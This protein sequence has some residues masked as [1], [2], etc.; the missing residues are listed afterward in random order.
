MTDRAFAAAALADD[1]RRL[2]I[3]SVFDRDGQID[4]FVPHSLSALRAHASRIVVVVNGELTDGSRSALAG[5]ADEIFVRA[6]EGFDIGA[7]RAALRKLG[8]EIEE[9]D[10][11][12]LTNDTWY[13]PMRPWGPVF[14]RMDR[15][16]CDFWGM[17]DHAAS[18]AN[19][20]T[21]RGVAPYH[22]QSYWMAVRRPMF[23]SPEWKRYWEDLP[24]L[25][26]YV[27]A[28]TEHELRFTEHFTARGRV[29]RAAFPHVLFDTENPSLFEAETLLER[30]CPILKRRPLFHW[31]PL[32]DAYASVGAWT[33]ASAAEGGYP[34]ELILGN[35]ARTVPPKA[36]NVDVGLLSVLPPDD[37]VDGSD[38]HGAPQRVVAVVHADDGAVHDVVRRLGYLPRGHDLVVTTTDAETQGAIVAALAGNGPARRA[39]VRLLPSHATPA[40]AFLVGCRDV[41]LGDEY[42]LV[43]RLRAGGAAAPGSDAFLRDHAYGNLLPDP[44]YAASLLELF[45]REP[46]LGIA[47]PPLLHIGHAGLGESWDPLKPF[48]AATARALGIGVPLDDVS[49]L[50]PPGGMFVARVAALR[51]LAEAS[52]THE[53]LVATG[54]PTGE[55]LS[56][57]VERMWSSASGQLGYHTRTVASRELLST[58]HAFLEYDLDRMSATI[59][60]RPFEKIDFLRH[61]GWAGSGSAGDLLR[62]YVRRRHAWAVRVAR[63]LADPARYPGRMIPRA[64]RRR[65]RRAG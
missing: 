37:R 56:A 14:E 7:H 8:S 10:E 28:V 49:P 33:L 12:V 18:R 34:T 1:A 21:R 15:S 2:I 6:N 24:P 59:P 13:G 63:R 31:P 9:F 57:A 46:T 25:R 27:D 35:L 38:E 62:M 29:A 61:S 52:W 3:Y 4:G 26:T 40:S 19:P 17:T 60:G 58:S 36:M 11:I 5:V 48:F 32:L 41:L 43:V 50:A 22:L 23:A 44:E 65:L 53:D 45:H 47:F 30:G 55:G 54:P 42:D 64:I 39:D 16:P 51:L 20:F